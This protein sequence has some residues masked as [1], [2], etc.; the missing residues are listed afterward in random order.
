MLYVYIVVYG[1]Q[2]YFI[3]QYSCWGEF[4]YHFVCETVV[5][6]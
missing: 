2:S 1:V 6:W 5:E 4:I 3:I